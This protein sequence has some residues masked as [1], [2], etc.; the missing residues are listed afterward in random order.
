MAE[1]PDSV[2]SIISPKGAGA[3]ESK[4]AEESG[5]R[6]SIWQVWID[7]WIRC[8]FELSEIYSPYILHVIKDTTSIDEIMG[9]RETL[10]KLREDGLLTGKIYEKYADMWEYVTDVPAEEI[11]EIAYGGLPQKGE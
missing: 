2:I 7:E 3:V 5:W 6:K 9:S 10:I 11:K 8:N 1:K 4:P